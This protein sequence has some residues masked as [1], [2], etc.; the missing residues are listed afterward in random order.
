MQTPP[1]CYAASSLTHPDLIHS[2]YSTKVVYKT[3]ESD[4][5]TSLPRIL[6][7]F[8]ICVRIHDKLSGLADKTLCVWAGPA[9]WDNSSPPLSISSLMLQP[10]H[11]AE[12]PHC[13]SSSQSPMPLRMPFPPPRVLL[14]LP[15]IFVHL[16]NSHS[17]IQQIFTQGVPCARHRDTAVNNQTNPS[18]TQ[19]R[20]LG[21]ETS[22]NKVQE[23]RDPFL[24]LDVT[25]F[26]P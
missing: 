16:I 14:C 25:E 5:D 4:S 8:S 13:P 3:W 24:W 19:W 1:T 17:F 15:F 2:S 20:L 22:N 23:V 7:W 10:Q 21:G 26:L 18:C 9:H 11:M 6:Q 12:H